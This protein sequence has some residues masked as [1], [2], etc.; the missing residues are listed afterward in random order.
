MIFALMIFEVVEYLDRSSRFFYWYLFIYLML[1]I[2]VT[3]L[4]FY[5]V[6]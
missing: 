1:F 4:P 3:L 6:L 2:I 5:L